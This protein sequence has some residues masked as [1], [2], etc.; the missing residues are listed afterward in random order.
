[1]RDEVIEKLASIDN[2]IKKRF[3]K[4]FN[5]S[6]SIYEEP[7]FSYYAQTYS[8]V[9]N[10]EKK[11]EYLFDV[12]DNINDREDFFSLGS[13]ISSGVKELIK[14]TESYKLFNSENEIYDKNLY[15]KLQIPQRNIYTEENLEKQLIS[16]DLEKANFNCFRM[17]GLQKELGLDT[18]KDLIGKFTDFDYF[19]ESKMIRQVIFGDLNP[20]RQQKVQR[21]IIGELCTELM[22]HNIE[23]SSAS[24]DE[25]IIKS[26]ISVD[27][28]NQILKDKK[29]KYNF[30][31]VEPFSFKKI[32][33]E[34]N[35]F[36]KTTIK[37]N[38]E[39]KLEFKNVPSYYFPQVFK[40]YLGEQVNEYDMMFLFEDNLSKFIRPLFKP[41][42]SLSKKPK[43][44]Y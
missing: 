26:N 19:I 4:D 17:F 44:N 30:F 27:D 5:I 35:F 3:T 22:K 1:M 33:N 9:F 11:F 34:G 10:L 38:G 15:A 21:F 32:G 43:K 23:L 20:S 6:I 24:S 2:A 8:K 31:R 41:Q 16:I 39:E 12:L 28:V 29:E 7:Y 25:I 40:E 13:N 14:S 36:V 37:D 18:Y 42:N